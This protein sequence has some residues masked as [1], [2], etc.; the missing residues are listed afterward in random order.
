MTRRR[1]AALGAGAVAVL[2]V[3][4]LVGS[5]ERSRHA[6]RENAGIEGVVAAVGPLDSPSLKGFR[7]LTHFQCLVYT[8]GRVEY[9]LEL[10]VDREG[11]VVEAIDR[12][13]GEPE[14]WSLRED[15]ARAEV[16]VDRAEVERLIVMMCPDCGAILERG[17]DES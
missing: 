11:R 3:L 2:L 12:R 14:F 4:V 6:D 1:L 7:L 16:R 17:R 10:C 8:R 5:W 13:S 15:R 9:A